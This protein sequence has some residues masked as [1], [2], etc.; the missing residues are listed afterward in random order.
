MGKLEEKMYSRNEW[1]KKGFYT[2]NSF[3]YI[4][5]VCVISIL[6][7]F[8]FM[9][10]AVGLFK[11]DYNLRDYLGVTL[12]IVLMVSYLTLTVYSIYMLIRQYS[13]VQSELLVVDSVDDSCIKCGDK[14]IEFSSNACPK[15]W[16]FDCWDVYSAKRDNENYVPKSRKLKKMYIKDEF[17]TVKSDRRLVLELVKYSSGK[18]FAIR[19]YIVDLFDNI[20]VSM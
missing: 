16:V 18:P 15:K 9:S 1:F 8:P 11:I 7:L 12:C 17:S 5:V 20:L 10:I 4:R 2:C 3:L 13:E 19:F 6:F 14:L